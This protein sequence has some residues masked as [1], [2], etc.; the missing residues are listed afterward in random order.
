VK[1][2]RV[3]VRRPVGRLH[4]ADVTEQTSLGPRILATATARTEQDAIAVAV[5]EA[6]PKADDE[7]RT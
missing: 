5:R 1:E 7:D 3:I 2:Y 4:T 6:F